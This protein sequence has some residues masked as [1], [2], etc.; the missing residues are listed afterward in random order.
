MSPAPLTC[1]QPPDG[2]PAVYVG[3]W[4]TNSCNLNCSYCYIKHKSES[5]VTVEKAL[6]MLGGELEREGGLMDILFM[7][8]ETLTHFE[9]FREIFEAI[10]GRSWRRPFHFTI[11]TNGTL[12]T[13]EMKA[14][15]TQRRQLVTLGLSCDGEDEAQDL[16]RCGSSGRIDKDYFIRTWPEQRWKMTISAATAARTDRNVIAMHELGVPFS[17]NAAYEAEPWPERSI[18]EYELA[19][20]RLADYYISRPELKPC[21]LLSMLSS[22]L[23]EPEKRRQDSY[24]GAGVSLIFFDMEGAAYPCHML[25]PL[26]MP[27]ERALRGRY[28]APG[29]DYEDPRCR[30]CALKLGCYTCLGTNY[31]YRGDIRLRDP[32][33][34]RLYQSQ[35]RATAHMWLGRL[36]GREAGTAVERARIRTA[37]KLFAAFREGRIGMRE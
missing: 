31:L 33:H 28:F 2:R 19:L 13:G 15:F 7:G 24:C 27:G 8:A 4:F 23:D 21:S 36:R 20:Y 37:Q 3:F 6:A 32:L 9:R 14:W 29:T 18:L 12:L 5:T 1:E 16:N 10:A 35:V 22:V 34:C 11:T 25:S 26:V 17:V 30:L